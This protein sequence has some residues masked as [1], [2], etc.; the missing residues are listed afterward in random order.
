MLSW[1]DSPTAQPLLDCRI[2]AAASCVRAFDGFRP[3][4][5]LFGI[6]FLLAGV[7]LHFTPAYYPSSLRDLGLGTEENHRGVKGY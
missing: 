3:A 2:A 4:G 6:C 1:Y 5:A 7:A